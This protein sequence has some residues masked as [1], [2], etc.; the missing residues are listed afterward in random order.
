MSKTSRKKF[1]EPLFRVCQE[2]LDGGVRF[3]FTYVEIDS[4]TATLLTTSSHKRRFPVNAS[5]FSALPQKDPR[6]T[7]FLVKL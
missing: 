4:T 6:G 3:S 1:S 5:E 7:L 2:N